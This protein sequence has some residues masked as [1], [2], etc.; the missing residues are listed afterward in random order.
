MNELYYFLYSIDSYPDIIKVSFTS[1]FITL[2]FT[3]LLLTFLIRLRYK[4]RKKIILRRKYES[5]ID[6]YIDKII[7]SERVFLENEIVTDFSNELQISNEIRDLAIEVLIY[8]LDTIST[9]S[10]YKLHPFISALQIDNRIEKQ[11]GFSFGN[12]KF[13]TIERIANLQLD[14]IESKVLPFAY[15]KNLLTRNIARNTYT[16]LSK[17]NPY[18]FF[19]DNTVNF[20]KWEEISLF[21]S[22]EANKN[23]SLPNFS[24]WINYSENELFVVFL[25]KMVA[26]FNQEESIES[27]IKQ[28]KNRSSKIREAAILA[29]GE[30]AFLSSE[31]DLIS[32]YN[33]QTEPCQI[34]IIKTIA[35]FKTANGL[36]FLENIY[37]KSSNIAVQKI[38]AHEIFGYGKTGKKIFYALKEDTADFDQL[39]LQHVENPLIHYKYA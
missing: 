35:K 38:I 26:Y 5:F 3:L 11:L 39:I 14:S 2:F 10:I 24:V 34:A 25:I 6:N 1:I 33:S 20:N 8:K 7:N 31:S 27:V 4:S 22:L 30:L 17:N 9:E 32:M 18:K 15:S 19:G 29:L 13:K 28:L 12:S 23:K 37:H 36:I 16:Q 21:K